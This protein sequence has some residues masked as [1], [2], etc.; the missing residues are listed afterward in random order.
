M[1]D[2][3][4][5]KTPE[6]KT[7]QEAHAGT[8]DALAKTAKLD[9]CSEQSK[10]I[11]TIETDTSSKRLE[12]LSKSQKTP[13]TV[14]LISKESNDTAVV[15]DVLNQLINTIVIETTEIDFDEFL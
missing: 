2:L 9:D 10:S 14:N 13:T 4:R 8:A 1:S 7:I 6:T 3:K 5:K 15:K 11:K 12:S